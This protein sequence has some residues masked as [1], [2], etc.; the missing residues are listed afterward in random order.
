MLLLLQ[1]LHHLQMKW[2]LQ[3]VVPELLLALKG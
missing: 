2:R 1:P 3:Q